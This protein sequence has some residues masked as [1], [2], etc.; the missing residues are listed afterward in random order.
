M[1]LEGFGKR[2]KAVRQDRGYTQKQLAAALGVTEQAVSKWERE[3]SYP[4]IPM[5]DGLST[6]LECSL[7][8]LFQVEEGRKNLL[9]Q[10]SIERKEEINGLLLPD[11]ISLEFGYDLVPMFAGEMENG[12]LHINEMRRDMASRWGIVM[13]PVRMRDSSSLQA[14][15]YRFRLNGI[16]VYTDVSNTLGENG[17]VQIFKNLKEHILKNIELV[18]NNQVIYSMVNNLREQYPYVVENIV[19][20]KISYSL[21]R[22]VIV[23]MIKEC[24]YTASPLILIIQ[25]LEAIPDVDCMEPAK[26]AE[27]I[28]ARMPKGYALSQWM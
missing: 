20:E 11:I 12:C 10:N 2:L 18:I 28:C 4:D 19:P 23:Y 9:N 8:F 6:V 25:H 13:P 24:R 21:L 1:A 26:L 15:E 27:E 17:I 5:I 7:D 16:T 3:S 14:M 22:Q